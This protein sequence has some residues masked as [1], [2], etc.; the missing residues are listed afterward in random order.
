MGKRVI[1]A[2]NTVF[3]LTI[4]NQFSLQKYNTFGIDVLARHFFTATQIWQVQELI[5]SNRYRDILVLG[6]GSNLL[7]T[8]HY[9]GLVLHNAVLGIEA[10]RHTDD[11]VWVQAHGG[12]NW[13]SLVQFC[14]AQGW[15]GIENLS[16]IPGTVGA[17]P[18]QNIGAYGVELC[19]VFD[20]LEAI[21]LISG[22]VHTFYNSDCRFGYRNSI[23]KQALKGQYFIT[24]VT[25]KLSKNPIAQLQY[26]EV[27]RTL[28]QMGITNPDVQAVSEAICHIRNAKL[29][30]P[31]ELGNCGSFFKNPELPP[32]AFAVL[33][34]QY[35]ALPHYTLPDGWVKVPAAWLIEQCGFKGKRVGN[36]GTH[37]NHALVI[38][39]YGNATGAE[40]KDFALQIQATVQER[41]GV[42]LEAEVNI[43]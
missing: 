14:V 19:N 6:G 34:A 40:I 39:N 8:R 10:T 12:E 26:G 43:L 25:L 11:Y 13:H 30:N 23:F 1:F 3:M 18:V 4:F 31:A 15:G 37:V 33:H 36:T 32:D 2:P 42:R 41:F 21:H 28:E 20:H 27:Q 5:E 17:A 9:N 22:K 24:S 16:L 38:V 29:P 35:P 7:F